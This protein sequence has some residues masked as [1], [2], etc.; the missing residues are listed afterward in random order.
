MRVLATFQNVFANQLILSM[1]RKPCSCVLHPGSLWV[2]RKGISM[3]FLDFGDANHLKPLNNTLFE[4]VNRWAGAIHSSH[5]LRPTGER[6]RGLGVDDAFVLT[7][8]YLTHKRNSQALCDPHPAS[9][10][11]SAGFSA[12]M[13]FDPATPGYLSLSTE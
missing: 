6:D 4:Q 11:R 7:S 3:N 5:R 8:E 12:V 10:H 13:S 1:L 2:T 9:T